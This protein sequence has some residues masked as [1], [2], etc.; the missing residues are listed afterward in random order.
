MR[1]W[2]KKKTFAVGTVLLGCLYLAGPLI[3]GYWRIGERD[4]PVF[5]HAELHSILYQLAYDES[6]DGKPRISYYRPGLYERPLFWGLPL[7]PKPKAER[8]AY[9]ESVIK[10]N[11]PDSWSVELI[12]EANQSID[13]EDK[14]S[15]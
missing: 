8:D 2:S 5:Y 14:K 9:V 15:P 10:R 6:I 11:G 12:R 3:A 1:R 7:R 13:N 4:G